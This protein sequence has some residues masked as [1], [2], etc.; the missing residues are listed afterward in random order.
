MTDKSIN[1][2]EQWNTA[3]EEAHLGSGLPTVV[4][5]HCVLLSLGVILGISWINLAFQISAAVLGQ[6]RVYISMGFVQ[7]GA[8]GL[9]IGELSL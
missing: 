5:L 2:R 9:G 8:L 3:R 7:Y 1:S 4:I 6:A